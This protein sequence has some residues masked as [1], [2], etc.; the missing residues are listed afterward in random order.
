MRTVLLAALIIPVCAQ[1]QSVTEMTPNRA[2]RG[3][4]PA[5]NAIWTSY[6]LVVGPGVGELE[7]DLDAT[8]DADLY[9]RRGQ[10]MGG[11][12]RQSADL[13]SNG[14]GGRES[15]RLTTADGLC[16][17]TYYI[18]VVHGGGVL[19]DR[20][21]YTLR[22]RTSE[23]MSPPAVAGTPT[24]VESTFSDDFRTNLPFGTEGLN[25]RT[26]VIDVDRDVEQLELQLRGAP[27]GA[28]ARWSGPDNDY[29]KLVRHALASPSCFPRPT[30]PHTSK[31]SGSA[32]YSAVARPKRLNFGSILPKCLFIAS[33]KYHSYLGACQAGNGSVSLRG[34]MIT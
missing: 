13:T 6:R 32:Y 24:D 21:K 33:A 28:H 1:A 31:R 29:S 8:G 25:Y 14:D 18:D 22:S 7:L 23:G 12:W 26:Y 3:A 17:C 5:S 20:L 19:G 30:H 27:S 11:N 9:V 10:T 34:N 4:L 15:I 16:A 2:Y